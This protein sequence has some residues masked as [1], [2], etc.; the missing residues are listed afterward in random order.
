MHIPT[1]PILPAMRELSVGA[2]QTMPLGRKGDS[3]A[4]IAAPMLR[5]SWAGMRFGERGRP[6]GGWSLVCFALDLARNG[7]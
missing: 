6:Y 3:A 7:T 1:S 2:E 4:R 5:P